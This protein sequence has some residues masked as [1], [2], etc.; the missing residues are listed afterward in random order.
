MLAPLFQGQFT[1]V[2]FALHPHLCP[3]VHCQ[4][5]EGVEGVVLGVQGEGKGLLEYRT[6]PSSRDVAHDRVLC[7]FSN[8]SGPDRGK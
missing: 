6:M 3:I 8:R 1:V 4:I 7:T 5:H 2:L